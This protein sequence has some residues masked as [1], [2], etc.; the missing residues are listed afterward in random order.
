MLWS[1]LWRGSLREAACLQCTGQQWCGTGHVPPWA[2]QSFP[3][4]PSQQDTRVWEL[5]LCQHGL[6]FLF[7]SLS[8]ELFLLFITPMSFQCLHWSFSQ[9]ISSCTLRNCVNGSVIFGQ[10]HERFRLFLSLP[11]LQLCYQ[12]SALSTDLPAAVLCDSQ[13]PQISREHF[14]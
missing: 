5:C 10:T 3:H 1:T 7:F 8:L 4:S 14:Y 12:R 2:L 9:L 11:W 13:H 6:S